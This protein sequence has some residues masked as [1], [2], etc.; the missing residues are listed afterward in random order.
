MSEKN[1]EIVRAFFQAALDDPQDGV[2]AFLA[3]E[4]EFFPFSQIAR[5][6]LGPEGFMNRIADIADQFERYEVRPERIQGVGDLVVADL[7]REAK[8][9]R[10]PAVISDRF[11]Q[12]FTLREGKITRIRSLPSYAEALESVGLRE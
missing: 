10:G 1:I 4:V 3:D 7:R 2:K 12:V 9:W 6:S 5:P 11:A 8:T